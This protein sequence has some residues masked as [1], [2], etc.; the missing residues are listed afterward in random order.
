MGARGV[1]VVVPSP[2]GDIP[3]EHLPTE[4]GRLNRPRI[5]SLLGIADSGSIIAVLSISLSDPFE[6]MEDAA[7]ALDRR[8]E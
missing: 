6:A 1:A 5:P 7:G 8:L 4:I 2:R 3:S